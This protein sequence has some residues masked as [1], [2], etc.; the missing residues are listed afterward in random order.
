ME[1]ITQAWYSFLNTLN[2]AL[3]YPLGSFS[4]QLGLPAV[5][6]LILGLI[7]ALSPCQLSTNAAALAYVNRRT[8]ESRSLQ[9]T[10]GLALAY[11]LGKA[12]TYTLLG[13]LAWAL[14]QGLNA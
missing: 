1:Q 7:G 5:T 6:A 12:T 14:G 9:P 13:A 2:A 3:S 4:D 10:Y 11:I 8:D